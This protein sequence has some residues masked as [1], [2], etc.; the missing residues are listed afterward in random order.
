MYGN[1]WEMTA[2]EKGWKVYQVTQNKEDAIYLVDQ[3]RK[4][5]IQCR[6][7][8]HVNKTV[9]ADCHFVWINMETLDKPFEP[10][11]RPLD[12]TKKK[13]IKCFNCKYWEGRGFRNL[14]KC[15]LTGEEKW[16]YLT[17]TKCFEWKK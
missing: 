12:K 2:E 1:T 13:N 5:K 3:L 11:T 10:K 8:H 4:L 6:R 16:G 17:R 15:V 14:G 9:G 7:I